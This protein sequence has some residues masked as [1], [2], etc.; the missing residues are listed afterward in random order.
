MRQPASGFV[1][2]GLVLA[3][4]IAAFPIGSFPAE[5]RLRVVAT[6]SIIADITRQIGGGSIDLVTLVGPDQD[7]HAFEPAGDDLRA[8]AGAGIV[9]A[10]GLGMEPWLERLLGSSG[11]GGRLVVASHGITPM[12]VSGGVGDNPHAFQDPVLVQSYIDNIAAGLSEADPENAA[13][14]SGNAAR[15]KQQFAELDAELRAAMGALPAGRKRILTTHD[16]FAYFGR[17]YGLQFIAIEGVGEAAEPSAQDLAR[18]IGQVGA[19]D[20]SAVFLENMND[21]R[22]VENLA[23]DT[24]IR[25]GGTLYSDALSK[26]GGPAA[27]L[28]SLFR[29]NERELLQA[30]R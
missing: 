5:A 24:G 23:S 2:L 29:H 28:L 13:A 6:F 14:F 30:L 21:P 10:N 12:P 4:A 3:L 25:V 7:V 15:L 22:F 1:R 11:F 19:G 17:A 18:I 8:V 27:D 16:A 9:V 26:S 20:I